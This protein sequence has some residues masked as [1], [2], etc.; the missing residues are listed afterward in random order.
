ML[1]FALLTTFTWGQHLSVHAR[2][3]SPA[4]DTDHVAVG[5]SCEN[6]KVYHDNV[7]DWLCGAAKH[8]VCL[9]VDLCLFGGLSADADLYCKVRLGSV[10]LSCA[11]SWGPRA[12][13]PWN[14]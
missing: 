1:H 14:T 3:T 13:H 12:Q 2:V 7:K 6:V 11:H 8:P 5:D 10:R 9:E 4:L